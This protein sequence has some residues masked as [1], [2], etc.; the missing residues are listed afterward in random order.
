MAL[1]CSIRLLELAVI[2]PK[3]LPDT[4]AF[5]IQSTH[6]IWSVDFLAGQRPVFVPAVWKLLGG[7]HWAIVVGQAVAAAAVWWW[8]GVTLMER[9]RH[10]LAVGGGVVA[11]SLL[12]SSL[13]WDGV[14]QG[15]SVAIT[16]TVAAVAVWLRCDWARPVVALTVVLAVWAL[17]KE[18]HAQLL[19]FIVPVFV[20][21]RRWIAAAV[22][23]GVFGF[24]QWSTAVGERWAFP[25]DNIVGREVYADSELAGWFED[26][27]MPELELSEEEARFFGQVNNDRA[28]EFTAY[29]EWRNAEGRGALVGWLA[30]HPDHAIGRTVDGL[31]DHPLLDWYDPE[32]WVP[33]LPSPPAAIA[34]PIAGIIA[35]R[36]RSKQ[37]AVVLG[38]AV[39]GAVL[40]ANSDAMEHARH[41]VVPATAAW[42]A[43]LVSLGDV[44]GRHDGE[45]VVRGPGDRNALLPAGTRAGGGA[46]VDRQDRGVHVHS[47]DTDDVGGACIERVDGADR[48]A[49]T[50]GGEVG[51]REPCWEAPSPVE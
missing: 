26:R 43:L 30:T 36:A 48:L 45:R 24:S 8:L 42:L 25:F 21:R 34:F 27:G 47:S 13:V 29:Q 22:L 7:N 44:D 23:V 46:V 15:E 14:L 9:S 12:P 19:V 50:G 2:E 3:V 37:G 5:Q 16:L 1:G 31:Q 10:R 20:W 33:V 38:L 18:T 40:A 35:I 4:A 28:G 51:R 32:G 49:W 11:V 6:P 41:L 39:V 17:T